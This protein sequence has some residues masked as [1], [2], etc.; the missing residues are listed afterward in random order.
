MFRAAFLA[1]LLAPAPA[2]AHPHVFIEAGLGFVVDSEGRLAAVR[3]E[4]AYDAYYTLLLFEDLGIDPDGDLKLTDDE[5]AK[6]RAADADWPD[7]YEG[8]LYGTSDGN[9]VALA[10]PMKFDLRLEGDR[11]IS[12]HYRPLATPLP[13][14]GHDIRFKTY[15]P[16]YYA[17]FELNRPVAVAGGTNCATHVVPADQ[18]AAKSKLEGLLRALQDSDSLEVQFPAVGADF[19]DEVQVTCDPS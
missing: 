9:A 12:S 2:L 1:A 5:M 4:W 15:D 18:A 7:D 8:D 11:I 6:L 19:A 17:A 3:V 14:A 10:P 16:S 13:V